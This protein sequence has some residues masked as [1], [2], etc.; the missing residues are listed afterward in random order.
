MG[1]GEDA[2]GRIHG[3]VGCFLSSWAAVSS[4]W[5]APHYAHPLLPQFSSFSKHHVKAPLPPHAGLTTLT[6]KSPATSCYYCLP[7]V[8]VN[9]PCASLPEP[10][11]LSLLFW[12]FLLLQ[13][14]YPPGSSGR[15]RV[16]GAGGQLTRSPGPLSS[17]RGTALAAHPC[18]PR[19]L[20]L[21]GRA[22]ERMTD[23]GSPGILGLEVIR[24]REPH[25]SWEALFGLRDHLGAHL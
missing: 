21:R 15:H 4:V 20:G 17:E 13:S 12:H 8:K 22:R 3:K 11:E 24:Y 2:G 5:A 1:E 19:S 23:D 7:G 10:S 25:S 16:R 6:S 9:Y 18:L 14:S